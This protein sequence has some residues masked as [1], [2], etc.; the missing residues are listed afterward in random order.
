[1]LT[2]L[3][4]IYAVGL[5]AHNLRQSVCVVYPETTQADSTILASF[6]EEY[7]AAGLMSEAKTLTAYAEGGTFGSGVI[8]RYGD[9][10]VVLTNRHV[11][12]YA[13]T[14]R[15]ELKL[16]REN[17]VFEHCPVLSSGHTDDIAAVLLPDEAHPVCVPMQV[18]DRALQEGDEVVAAGF[19][20][21]Q[22][23]PSW[24][25]T[26]GMVS[27]TALLVDGG[28]AYYVQHTASVDPGSSGGPLLYKSDGAYA[29]V[30]LNTIKAFYRDRV[31]LAVPVDSIL[32]FTASLSAPDTTDRVILAQLGQEDVNL[33]HEYY[34]AM[35]IRQRDSLAAIHRVLPLELAE[36][37]FAIGRTMRRAGRRGS[38][39]LKNDNFG[40]E[41]CINERFAILAGY[42][43]F[44]TGHHT[45]SVI[46]RFSDQYYYQAARIS[47]PIYALDSALSRHMYA[48]AVRYDFGGQL[49]LRL[50]RTNYLVPHASAGLQVGIGCE[51]SGGRS[52]NWEP[53]FGLP[54]QAGVDYRVKLSKKLVLVCTLGY[55]FQ[56]TFCP[57]RLN[58]PIGKTRIT[59]IALMHG[60]NAAVGLAF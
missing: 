34:A 38:S 11:V 40:V 18:A 28:D 10:L 26:S 45:A 13:S 1:M 19:P 39:T 6:A 48:I 36:D 46:I 30:G 16:Y 4:V 22:G 56:P 54:L 14:V 47:V 5:M 44:F 2:A 24:Q 20:G 59:D 9:N 27:N 29:I 37:V 7:A 23:K 49:P 33:F 25:L 8:V 43:Y 52:G 21:L 42:E 51:I 58:A 50:N 35:S 53:A 31:A 3:C 60:I 55:T 32:S 17:H 15:V 41:P 57:K 12:G